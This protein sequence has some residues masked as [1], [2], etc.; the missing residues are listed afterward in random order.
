[1]RKLFIVFLVLTV[2]LL[3][4][5]ALMRSERSLLYIA[6]WTVDT[7]TDLRLE[8]KQPVLRPLAGKVSASEIHL[9][10]KADDGP[11]FVSVLDFRGNISAADLYLGTLEHSRL[12]AAQ[13][14]IYISSRDKTSDPAPMEWLQYLSW[15]PQELSV[16]QLHVVNASRSTFIFP[17]RS[18]SGNRYNE[19]S[20]EATAAAQYEGEPLDIALNITALREGEKTTG[21]D[22]AAD[23]IAPETGSQVELLGELRGT[24]QDFTYDFNLTVAFLC[25][26]KAR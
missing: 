7:F 4:P 10:P 6:Y 5:L 16:D 12:Q 26:R 25:M 8:I 14:T 21:I 11:P 3:L 17:L 22:L 20:F 23:F 1:M 9:F 13:V 2:L 24:L 19:S 18:L 15:L